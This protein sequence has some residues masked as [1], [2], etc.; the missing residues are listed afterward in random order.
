MSKKIEQFYDRGTDYE[1]GRLA[2]H[3]TEFAVTQR[4]LADYLPPSPAHV[5]DVGGGPGRYAL[6]LAAQG[7]RVT[8][9]DL[10]A[11]LLTTAQ[12]QAAAQGV[13]L[14][15]YEHGTA[16]DLTR[17]RAGA[18]DAVL[19]MG[20]LYHLIDAAEREQAVREAY[21]VLRPGGIIGATFITRY[22]AVRNAAQN[23]PAWIVAQADAHTRILET[24]V[25]ISAPDAGFIDA[26]F[27][28][29]T[30]I[31]PLLENGGFTTLDLIACEGVISMIEEQVNALEDDNLFNAW[32]DLNYRLGKDPS[33]HGAAEHLLYIGRKDTPAA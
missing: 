11:E 7:Y 5:L 20:P 25:H 29:P 27:T 8:L 10:S 1:W 30:A 9:F 13:T 18:F 19:L 26:Y 15:G 32:A 3:R 28:H 23:D 2:R 16:T 17:F 31:K 22:A 4:A 24:G 14:A 12:T 21:R 6:W 33:V